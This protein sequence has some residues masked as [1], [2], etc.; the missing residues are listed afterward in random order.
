MSH[1]VLHITLSNSVIN[2]GK[3][4]ITEIVLITA[5][6]ASNV[7]I[8]LIISILEYRDTPIVTAKKLSPLIII[9]L[10]E[11]LWAIAT[12]SFFDI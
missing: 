7:Q 10:I 6:R 4:Q 8:E 2:A 1:V 11:V 9:D 12:A 3:M 5:P